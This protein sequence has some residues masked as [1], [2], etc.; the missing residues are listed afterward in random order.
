MRVIAQCNRPFVSYPEWSLVRSKRR[1]PSGVLSGQVGE[2]DV[3]KLTAPT[4]S[5]S[6]SIGV[7]CISR[8]EGKK[9]R[10]YSR[11]KL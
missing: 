7:S 9:R 5:I 11:P 3:A 6:R 10:Y 4:S 2:E 1:Y 8:S